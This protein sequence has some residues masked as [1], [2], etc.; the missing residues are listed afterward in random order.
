MEHLVALRK[1][2]RLAFTHCDV[3]SDPC[4]CFFGFH[5][6]QAIHGTQLARPVTVWFMAVPLLV[7]LLDAAYRRYAASKAVPPEC[8]NIGGLRA[9]LLCI[10]PAGMVTRVQGSKQLLKR[11]TLRRH[12][13]LAHTRAR[14][15]STSKQ[16]NT[17][18]QCLPLSCTCR[19][20][21]TYKAR[22]ISIRAFT[23]VTRIEIERPFAR[24]LAG[25][26]IEL[27]VPAIH[28]G[29]YHPF[30]I[31]SGESE[32]TLV[33]Y[34]KATGAWTQVRRLFRGLLPHEKFAEIVPSH[35]LLLDLVLQP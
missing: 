4:L 1:M 14:K 23:G 34:I 29:V 25:Q 22:V 19:W 18:F 6:V 8:P 9:L 24:F 13:L 16:K 31:A 12:R 2:P 26:Y 11:S 21:R 17:A 10:F 30:S 35:S 27:E 28:K 5:S 3:R 20:Q 33:L 32:Q 7:C 15:S